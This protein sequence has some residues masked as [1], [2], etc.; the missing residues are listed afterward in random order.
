M[1]LNIHLPFIEEEIQA[2]ES[3]AYMKSYES[4]RVILAPTINY[5]SVVS[6]IS[7]LSL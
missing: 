1:Y 4:G 6:D 5:N 2:Q 7:F 3:F